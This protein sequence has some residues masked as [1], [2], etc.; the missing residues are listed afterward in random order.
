MGRCCGTSSYISLGELKKPSQWLS[1]KLMNYVQPSRKKKKINSCDNKIT[2]AM[3]LLEVPWKDS[4][5]HS[6]GSDSSV[7]QCYLKDWLCLIHLTEPSS[8]PF[9]S[10]ENEQENEQVTCPSIPLKEA[11]P[12]SRPWLFPWSPCCATSA[13]LGPRFSF[14]FYRIAVLKIHM[15]CAKDK[16]DRCC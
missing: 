1:G 6:W 13:L 5:D 12:L 14:R 10:V 2:H 16:S 7:A 8:H 11:K 15:D 3:L 4:P 9:F